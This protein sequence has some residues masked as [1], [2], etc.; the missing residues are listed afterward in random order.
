M[1][2]WTWRSRSALSMLESCRPC[3]NSRS[4]ELL[5]DVLAFRKSAGILILSTVTNAAV[6][7]TLRLPAAGQQAAAGPHNKLTQFCSS[8]AVA[9]QLLKPRSFMRS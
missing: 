8:N 9:P 6:A 7:K 2:W 4:Y 5:L 3:L 1:K